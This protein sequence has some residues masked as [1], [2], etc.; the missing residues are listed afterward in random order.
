MK[1]IP[2]GSMREEYNHNVLSESELFSD[3]FLQFTSW[4]EH[5]I[6]DTRIREANAMA[7]STVS[8]EGMPSSRM[9]LLKEINR[10]GLVFFTNY[11]SRKGEHLAHN[12]MASVLFFWEPLERQIRVEGYVEKLDPGLSDDY[13]ATRPL[14][15]KISAISSAQSTVISHREELVRLWEHHATTMQEPGPSRPAFWG[16]YLLSPV[17]FEFWQG[18]ENRLHDRVQ[19]RRKEDSWVIERLAP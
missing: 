1:E 4:L 15:S 6:K 16:G 13:F 18:R 10:E 8:A 11:Q 3:P 2:L 19:F 17:L 12:P 7:L 14:G 5:A 9:V